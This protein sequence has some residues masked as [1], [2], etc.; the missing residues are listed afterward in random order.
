MDITTILII[1]G[2]AIAIYI[3]FL[4]VLGFSL[5]GKNIKAQNLK[6]KN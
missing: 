4:V 2:S 5:K 6:D 3:A 1:S